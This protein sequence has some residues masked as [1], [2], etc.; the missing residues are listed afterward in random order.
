MMAQRI[1]VD[2]VKKLTRKALILPFA[3]DSYDQIRTLQCQ[4]DDGAKSLCGCCEK[5]DKKGADSPLRGR[6]LRQNSHASMSAG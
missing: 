2:A 6:F 4:H 3:A 5:T 1:S